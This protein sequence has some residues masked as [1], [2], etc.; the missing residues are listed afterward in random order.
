MKEMNEKQKEIIEK[1][2]NLSDDGECLELEAW[3][4]RG[5]D[6]ILYLWKDK[7]ENI[8]D[9]LKYYYE[10]FDIDEEIDT[11]RQ[12]RDYCQAF[13]ISESLRDFEDWQKFIQ[14]VIEELEELEEK[15]KRERFQESFNEI[16]FYMSII[17]KDTFLKNKFILMDIFYARAYEIANDYLPHDNK[18]KSLIE[19]I[20][21]YIKENNENIKM[22][23]SQCVEV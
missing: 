20:N 2:F 9:G 1:K 23:L 12:S 6:M 13:T 22:L 17:L 21:D 5:V 16:L 14:G 8:I 19:S 15:E 10:N 18:K 4:S 7:H 11:H 3:T